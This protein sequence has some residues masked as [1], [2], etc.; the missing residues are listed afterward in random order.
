VKN[1]SEGLSLVA[2]GV[3]WEA[4]DN[5]IAVAGEYPS[6]VYRGPLRVGPSAGS[7]TSG[8][9]KTWAGSCRPPSIRPVVSW[10][11]ITGLMARAMST[12]GPA[13]RT[14]ALPALPRGG[15]AHRPDPAAL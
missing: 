14:R 12:A 10:L 4:G 13:G 7:N 3:A 5:V 6:N 8:G 9:S 2:A 11:P 1:T 15:A